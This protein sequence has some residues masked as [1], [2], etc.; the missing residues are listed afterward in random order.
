[1]LQKAIKKLDKPL[2][3]ID[4]KFDQISGKDDP[5]TPQ[6]EAPGESLQKFET[7]LANAGIAIAGVQD[8]LT[9][10]L[11]Q[12]EIASAA[13]GSFQTAMAVATA[14]GETWSGKYAALDAAIESQMQ[15]RND[16][17]P[18]VVA[19]YKGVKED[20]DAFLKMLQDIDFENILDEL[21]DLE[22]I[23]ELFAFLEKPLEIAG[24]LIAPILPLLNAVDALVGLIIN[25]IIDYV[26]ETLSLDS[27]LDGATFTLDN[28]IPTIGVLEAFENLFQPIQDFLLEYIIDAL[29]T[30]EYLDLVEGAFFGN[31]AGEADRGPTGWGND[32][33]NIL[34]ATMV[35]TFSTHLATATSSWARAATM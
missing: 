26:M 18:N 30:L 35:T 19:F 32:V 24:A 34:M 3:S 5:K 25:P 7:N 21:I 28:L 2:D 12:L 20:V 9:L 1:M 10:R 27:L 6:K 13:S 33:A 8:A 17:I 22:A 31:V 16:L 23:G 4:E 29:G 15:A 14:T 11:R